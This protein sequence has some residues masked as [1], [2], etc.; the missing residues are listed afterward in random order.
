MKAIDILKQAQG[1]KLQDEDGHTEELRLLPG[2]TEQELKD[3]EASLPCPLPEERG[4]ENNRRPKETPERHLAR[5]YG[6][7][8]LGI[9]LAAIGVPL[10]DMILG[11][12]GAGESNLGAWMLLFFGLLPLHILLK[13]HASDGLILVAVVPYYCLLLYVLH[14]IGRGFGWLVAK[15]RLGGA[16]P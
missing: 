16:R 9:G 1:M 11:I 5:A 3:L 8:A 12:S 7:V 15:C 4:M 2:L 13:G 14:R 6:R 10:I